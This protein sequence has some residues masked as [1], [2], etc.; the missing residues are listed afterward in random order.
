MLAGLVLSRPLLHGR[1][2]QLFCLQWL[3]YC[4]STSGFS[5]K[6]MLSYYI[7]FWS[8]LPASAVLPWSSLTGSGHCC[9]SSPWW[10]DLVELLK[11]TS[12]LLKPGF[13]W[14]LLSS[15][16]QIPRPRCKLMALW[17]FSGIILRAMA[18]IHSWVRPSQSSF[19]SRALF[20]VCLPLFEYVPFVCFLLSGMG[21]PHLM[22]YCYVAHSEHLEIDG[23]S[24][25]GSSI[26]TF[27][28]LVL[29]HKGGRLDSRTGHSDFISSAC[30]LHLGIVFLSTEAAIYY[31]VNIFHAPCLMPF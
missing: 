9:H 30:Q 29:V 27:W 31:A 14:G 2:R 11:S 21:T 22:C 8:V 16:M 10:S 7:S 12:A 26:V 24:A 13:P 19:L 25:C 23:G 4:D 1:D 15:K 20:F 28:D 6:K 3:Y 5:L 17:M 18:G